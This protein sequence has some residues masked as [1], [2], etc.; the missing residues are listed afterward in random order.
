M[1]RSSGAILIAALAICA[2]PGA[3]EP[4]AGLDTTV[5]EEYLTEP[6]ANTGETPAQQQQRQHC[7]KLSREIESLEGKPLRRSAAVQR[8]KAECQ[9]AARPAAGVTPSRGNPQSGAPQR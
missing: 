4:A 8:H 3:A 9:G 6:A 5:P 1:R 7:T 2:A